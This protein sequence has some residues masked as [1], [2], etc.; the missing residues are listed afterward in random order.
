MKRLVLV[1]ALSLAAAP[2]WAA[3][4]VEKKDTNGDGR[5]DT[6]TTYD[7]AGV[8]TEIRSDRSHKDGKVDDWV[9]LKQGKVVRHEWDRNFDGKPDFKL[10]QDGKRLI[11][12]QYDDNF[13]GK[14][15]RTVK[16]PEPGTI[17]STPT[18]PPAPGPGAQK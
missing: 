18:T 10:F 11:E 4:R 3:D 15:E 16:A 2:V 9:Y 14:Y 6:W 12:K 13:D 17:D 7:K 5:I 1:L 8:P